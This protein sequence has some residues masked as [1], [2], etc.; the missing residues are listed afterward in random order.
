MPLQKGS[1]MPRK[2]SGNALKHI[3][4]YEKEKG[5]LL[6]EQEIRDNPKS[7]YSKFW[8]QLTFFKKKF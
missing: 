2:N 4:R 1:S 5:G 8:L 7:K 6:F 3:G